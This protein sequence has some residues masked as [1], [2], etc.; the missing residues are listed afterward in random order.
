MEKLPTTP[1]QTIGP[2]F[3]YGLTPEQ[4]VYPF[5]SIANG[6]MVDVKTSANTIYI[7]GKVYDGAGNSIGDAMIEL[8]QADE[9][10]E[11]RSTPLRKIND[12]FTGFGRLGT[13]TEEDHSFTFCTTKPAATGGFAPHVNVILFMRGS[14][15]RLTTRLYFSDEDNEN[16][17]LW[18]SLD[19]A[20]RGTLV[21]TKKTDSPVP[22]YEFFIHMQGE[23]ETVFFQL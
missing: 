5:N 22:V 13:G 14:L 23:N 15:L 16:D 21:A 20:R 3:A 2:F 17:P 7:T 19:P 6:V 9:N 1:S 8:W 10:G 18:K 4:Y 11:Y 12:G